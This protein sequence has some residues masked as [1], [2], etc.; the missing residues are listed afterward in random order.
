MTNR[1][2]GQLTFQSSSVFL[3]VALASAGCSMNIAQDAKTG[4]D[5]KA[6]G[7]KKI[8]I[9]DDG[10]GT[11]KGV[12]TYP[13]GDR[14]DWRMF[15][16]PKAGDVT[17]N[18]KWVPAKPGEDLAFNV[19]D[20]TFH[21]IRRVAPTPDSDKVRK[22]A[23]LS[24][25]TPGKYY[26]QIYAPGR[27]DAGEYEVN[28][29]WSEA[30]APGSTVLNADPLPNPPRLPAV[31]GAVSAAA[32]GAAPD[33]SK[34]KG[35]KDNPCQVGEACAPGAL[36]VNPACPTADPMPIGSPC[37]PQPVI[38]PA[39]PDAGPLMPGAPCPPVI[40]K[41]TGKIIE[42]QQQGQE[43]QITLD[44]GSNQGIQKG[45]TGVVFKG[46][47]GNTPLANS[48][49]VILRVT[50]TESY[51]KL[52]KVTLEALGENVRVELTS[53]PPK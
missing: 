1:T 52:K 22:T 21:V 47:T 33:K 50:E 2:V 24:A 42:R 17:V 3:A 35:S 9:G 20:D 48:E 43:V 49:F 18:L 36:Y 11:S 34:P 32:G 31:P 13:G 30:R 46:K 6:K 53:P 39:C 40:V 19:F 37:P 44:K 16:I 8:R 45:W 26:V 41:K 27:G 7:A 23:E 14:V 51:A 5:G 15:E 12:V 38:N 28:V 4:P 29:H 25:L 10:E